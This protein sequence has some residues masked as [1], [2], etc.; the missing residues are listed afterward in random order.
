MSLL[1]VVIP[2]FNHAR[3]IDK[4]ISSVF[5]Q[6]YRPIELII[7]DDGSTD[8]SP[9]IIRE[10]IQDHPIENL[11]FLEQA[12]QGAHA[13]IMRGIS[14]ARGSYLSVLNSDD[15]YHSERFA[16]MLPQIEAAKD[17]IA[18]SGVCFVDTHN[19]ILPADH[20]W[21]K[22][23][24]KCL[25]EVD[26]CPTIGYGLLRHNFSVTSGNFVFSRGLYEKLGGFSDHRFVHDWDFLLRSCYF[27]EPIFVSQQLINYRIHETNTTKFVRHLLFDESKEA[28][29]R[30]AD[31]CKKGHPKN[32]LAPCKE[33]WPR[34]FERFA[35]QYTPP[36]SE[37][38]TIAEIAGIW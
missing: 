36:S 35:S 20:G 27:G 34:F 25:C 32:K 38:Q 21:P 14:E 31:M 24:A 8:S 33:H 22:W 11:V 30:F 19:Q 2:S 18:F 9:K 26:S 28:L 1:S 37:D 17:C 4:A 12:N 13:A 6:T 10:A 5:S 7:V 15:F 29:Q 3:F 23:Y 16:V